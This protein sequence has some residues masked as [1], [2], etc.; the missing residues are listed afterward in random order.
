M[1][2]AS[3]T[4][5][6]SLRRGQWARLAVWTAALAGVFVCAVVGLMAWDYAQRLAKDPLDTEEFKQL[7]K[8]VVADPENE[9]LKKQVEQWD[10]ELR[11]AYFRQRRF[12]S[13]GA[14]LLLGGLAVLLVAMRTA[15]T[16]RR[17]LP[18]PQVQ[19]LLSDTETPRNSVARWAVG[20]LLVV[21]VGTAIGL[22]T[23]IGSALYRESA[24][25][26]A[27]PGETSLE[28]PGPAPAPVLAED[29]TLPTKEE[30]A[31]NWPYFR[32]PGG[33]GIS[34]YDN[35]PTTWD[36][37]KDEG[38]VWKTPVPLQGNSSPI[39]WNDRIFLTGATQTVRQVYCFDTA[40]GKL[41]W[42]KD[43]PATAASRGKLPELNEETGY[44]CSTPATDGQRV[45]AWFAIG[46][47]AAFDFSGNLVWSKS[48]GIPRNSYGHGTSLTIW[49]SLLIVQYDQALPKD[50][51]SKLMALDSRTGERVWE[52]PREVPGSWCTPIV[53]ETGGQEQIV[54]GANPWV[55]A[56][57]P[58]DGKELWR[59]ECLRGDVVASPVSAN[60][61]VYAVHESPQLS[62]IRPNGQGDVTA[63]H[64]VW[65]GED[66]LPDTCSPLAT[67]EYVLL[68]TSPGVLTCYDAKTGKKLW[69]QDFEATFKAS[70]SLAGKYVYLVSDTDDGK[71]FI[72]EPGPTACKKVAEAK[73][74]EPSVASPAFQDGRVYVRG[75][76]HLFCVGKK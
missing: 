67:P 44:A 66:G 52:T 24:Q 34:A 42:Q 50:R 64:I 17:K 57:R 74:G 38:I 7:K 16:L 43:M 45:F 3:E 76:K 69:E 23:G 14:W 35:V 71:V 13:R 56:Y 10:L 22:S 20:G 8:Q 68:L 55:I 53:I 47:L 30:I 15:A 48:L 72:V 36:A 11:R 25:A 58:A 4:N 54:T 21:L 6:L 28:T 37:T 40:T 1:A 39:V 73:M 26:P 75:K 59:A 61:L 2:I 32:G 49:R 60:G 33:L 9:E 46:D 31:K 63:S 18:M 62:A 5:D 51:K 27:E 29:P 70:P 19:P 65:T 41:L 12:A